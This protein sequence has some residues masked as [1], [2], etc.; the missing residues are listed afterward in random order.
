MVNLKLEVGISG[1]VPVGTIRQ[2]LKLDR[3]TLNLLMVCL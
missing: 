1:V 3:E 2:S